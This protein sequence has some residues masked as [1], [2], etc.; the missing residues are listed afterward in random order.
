MS[1][2][3]F[4][5]SALLIV[6]PSGEPRPL[7]GVISFGSEVNHL[8]FHVEVTANRFIADLGTSRSTEVRIGDTATN[9][10]DS[11]V[12]VAHRCSAPGECAAS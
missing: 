4:A 9:D 7:G 6:R 2:G 5:R 1:T 10:A 11:T 8:V 12:L 3:F